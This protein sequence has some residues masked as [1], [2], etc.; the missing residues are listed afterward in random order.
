[1][2]WVVVLTMLGLSIGPASTPLQWVEVGYLV[3][4][5]SGS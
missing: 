2:T 3:S 1:M 5:G 4:S